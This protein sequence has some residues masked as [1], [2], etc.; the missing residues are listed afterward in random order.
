MSA[1]LSG[2]FYQE[3]QQDLATGM[4][5][6]PRGRIAPRGSYTVQGVGDPAMGYNGYGYYWGQYPAIVGGTS[7][8]QAMSTITGVPVG[9]PEPEYQS[10]AKVGGGPAQAEVP[11]Y[12][13]TAAY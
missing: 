9:T 8:Y 6:G 5:G 13:G 1:P 4:F 10:E 11:D 2:Q 12:G 3:E 7:D